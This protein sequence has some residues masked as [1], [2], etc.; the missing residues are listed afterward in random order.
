VTES[1]EDLSGEQG[2]GSVPGDLDLPGFF[3]ASD[4]ASRAGQRRRVRTVAIILVLTVLAAI[5]G[6]FTFKVTSKH[7]DVGGVISG[8]TFLIAL[9]CSIYLL[10]TKPERDWYEGRAGAESA[11]TLAWLYMVGGDPFGVA[12]CADPD[13]ELINRL[14]IIAKQ[15]R[16]LALSPEETGT[17]ITDAMRAIRGSS[18]GERKATY[19]RGRIDDQLGWYKKKAAFNKRQEK[20]WLGLTL[21]LQGYGLAVAFARVFNVLNFDLLGVVAAAVA[22][23]AAWIEA[24]D[25]AT[26][27]S[28]YG[29]TATDLWM[30]RERALMLA[31]NSSEPAWSNFVETAE[32]AISREHTLWLARG[33]VH[34]DS[35]FRSNG[36]IWRTPPASPAEDHR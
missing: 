32:L 2:Q 17:Q 10:L 28:A 25:H 34:W 30:A 6:T 13:D 16:E 8:L 12:S 4:A 18:L 21:V 26:L 1:A 31:N 11:R 7:I 15:L 19:L 27:G 14:E 23:T 36:Q 29:I 35:P 33:G 3:R 24:K 5:S 20:F 9:G 22:A